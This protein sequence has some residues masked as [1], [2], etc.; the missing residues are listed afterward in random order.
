MA[1]FYKF[2][3]KNSIHTNNDNTQQDMTEQSKMELSKHTCKLSSQT[4]NEEV[5]KKLHANTQVIK[6]AKQMVVKET[7]Q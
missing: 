2:Q 6:P 4:C 7:Y 3:T 5:G 1:P